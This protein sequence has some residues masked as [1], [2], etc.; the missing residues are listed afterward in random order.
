MDGAY[1]VGRNEILAWINATLHLNISRIEE[2]ASG[3]IQCQMMDICHTR[4]VPMH[5]VNF[6]AK[7]EYDMIQNY[8]ILQEVFNKLKVEKHPQHLP[9]PSINPPTRGASSDCNLIRGCVSPL[10]PAPKSLSFFPTHTHLR[11]PLLPALPIFYLPKTPSTPLLKPISASKLPTPPPPPSPSDQLYQPFRRPPPSSQPAPHQSL[12]LE[13]LL[14]ILRNRL[15]LCHHYAPHI[16]T[17][18][19]HFSFLAPALEESTGISGSEQNRLIVAVQVRDSLIASKVDDQVLSFFDIPGGA[20]LLYE[21][22]LLS[23]AQRVA[24][25]RYFADRHDVARVIKDFP[26]R[27]GEEGWECFSPTPGDCL[28]FM[29]FRLSRE[30]RNEAEWTVALR[31]AMEAVDTDRAKLRGQEGAAEAG[32]GDVARRAARS[33]RR[34]KL[35]EAEHHSTDDADNVSTHPT[36]ETNYN[37]VERRCKGAKERTSKTSNK[38]SKS[39]QVNNTLSNCSV[40]RTGFNASGP[41][42]GKVC[43][44]SGG[45]NYSGQIQELTKQVS[46]LNI[47]ASNLEKERDFYF[48]KLRDIEILCQSPE[49]EQTLVGEAIRKILYAADA[50]KSPLEEAQELITRSIDKEMESSICQ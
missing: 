10:L 3:A 29:H 5:K 38:A 44:A 39:L 15:S 30:H 13:D 24:T 35:S 19:R 33:L 25:A 46:E 34:L 41:K 45:P 20:E 27:R 22:C 9:A 21:L 23:A 17:L 2:A 42:Q 31:C 37:P 48:A 28:A 26:R 18:H 4:V 6:E 32:D 12:S 47:F 49:L 40:D 8:K 50:G 1:F 7:T 16:S 43:A 11:S 36:A 14:D